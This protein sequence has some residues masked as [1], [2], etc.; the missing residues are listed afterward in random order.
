MSENMFQGYT[1]QP[2]PGASGFYTHS[3]SEGTPQLVPSPSSFVSS[4]QPPPTSVPSTPSHQFAI[5]HDTHPSHPILSCMWG[6]CTATFSTMNE[7]VG[8]VNLEHLRLPSA[9]AASSAMDLT[10]IDTRQQQQPFDASNPLSCLWANCQVYPTPASV[11]GPS[12]GNQTGNLLGVLA[13]HLLQDHLGLSMRPP[14]ASVPSLSH[15]ALGFQQQPQPHHAHQHMHHTQ[16]HAQ[17]TPEQ[18]QQNPQ[19][20]LQQTPPPIDTTDPEHDFSRD[21]PAS[22]PL[23]P[24]PEHDCSEPHAHVCRWKDCGQSF[25]SCDALTAH[26][27]STHVGSGKAHYDCYWDNCQRHGDNGFASKQKICRHLQVCLTSSPHAML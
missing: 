7:L 25:A 16:Q 12:S 22:G 6:N 20:A 3:P 8:H 10:H 1:N 11:P 19:Q 9:P 13:N 5:A 18:A 14:S 23:T 24:A 17:V 2:T 4:P 15:D 27:T 26:I 21:S